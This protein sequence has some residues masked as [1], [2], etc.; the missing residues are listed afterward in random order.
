MCAQLYPCKD[1]FLGLMMKK[2]RISCPQSTVALQNLGET[3]YPYINV[4][5][6]HAAL[7]KLLLRGTC[8]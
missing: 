3:L 4:A 1:R 6:L 2:L 5:W 8:I 7:I